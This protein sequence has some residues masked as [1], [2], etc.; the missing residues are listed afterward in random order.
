MNGLLSEHPLAELISEIS[1]KTLWGAL[2]VVRDRA[3]AVIYFE[4]GKV[5]YATTNL[6]NYRLAEYLQKQ[7]LAA[8]EQIAAAE[9]ALTDFAL[10]AALMA[11]RVLTRNALDRTLDE[12]VADVLRML[13]LW[14]DGEWS[15]DDRARLN[16]PTRVAVQSRQLLIESARRMELKFA[17]SRFPNLD[18][19]ISH[20]QAPPNELSLS[21][22]EG[23][24]LSRV[25]GPIAVGELTVLSG[26]REP[27]ALQTIYGLVLAGLL[28]R[29]FW[30]S[31]FRSATGPGAARTEKVSS[32]AVARQTGSSMVAGPERDPKQELDEFL[33]RLSHATNHYEVLNVGVSADVGEIRQAYHAVARRFHPDRFHDLA[34]TSIHTRL[35]SAFARITRANE[36]LA[37]HDLRANY[38]AKISALKEN[39][40]AVHST[41]GS[42][43]GARATDRGPE[44]SAPGGGDEQLAE[45][46][47]QEG[48]AAL[49]MAQINA[50]ISSL[51]AAARLAPRQ[52]RYR[53]S[54][55]RALATQEKTRRL[56]EGELRAAVNLDATN[57]S[58]RV[59]LA[60]LYRDLGFFRRAVS[61]LKRALSLDSQNAEA[62]EMLKTLELSKK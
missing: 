45:K 32:A 49:K 24:M 47:F 42:R 51:S 58:Y 9:N 59:M 25:E 62:R 17:A 8:A 29:E 34:G 52:A 40:R 57:G 39:P 35:E 22:T 56:A 30:P 20:A 5:I 10:A 1:T 44:E 21:S 38:D 36:T 50:A 2:R 11:N 33:E 18:E 4:T 15:F 37:H 3:K 31:A 41:K 23:F 13:L 26:Q 28:Q 53:A 12:Q 19:V 16:D 54:Y 48:V 14:P 60:A 46:R 7:G 55:G 43:E 61:E 6:H 27:E